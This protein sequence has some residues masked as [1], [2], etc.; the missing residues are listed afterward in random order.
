MK[1]H[2][3]FFKFR[4]SAKFL[5]VKWSEKSWRPALARRVETLPIR[6][7]S[8]AAQRR[9]ARSARVR[10]RVEQSVAVLLRAAIASVNGP[11]LRKCH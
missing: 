8:L 5:K 3:P 9:Q 2:I 1:R 10:I 4:K 11:R 7:L 6:V